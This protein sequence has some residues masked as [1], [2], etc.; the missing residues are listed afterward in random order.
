MPEIDVYRR[1]LENYYSRLEAHYRDYKEYLVE[2][3]KDFLKAKSEVFGIDLEKIEVVPIFICG[4][5]N[6]LKKAVIIDSRRAT[7]LDLPRPPEDKI[8]VD[9]VLPVNLKEYTHILRPNSLNHLKELVGAPSEVH[10]VRTQ[11]NA[12]AFNLPFSGSQLWP[13]EL[14][15]LPTEKNFQFEA[16]RPEQRLAVQNMGLNLLH[17]S[18]DT[19]MIKQRPYAAIVDHV[20]RRASQLPT[21]LC[22]DLIVCPDEKVFF[23]NYAA[24]YFNNV[25]VVGNGEIHLGNHTKLHAYQ[26]RHI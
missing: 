10:Q 17:G 3:P 9:N 6:E 24:V 13:V 1:L 4:I 23:S 14:R 16:L 25:L 8:P 11:T 22:N 18:V 20:L 19:E 2:P 5:R 21:F 7:D 26:I 15:H 12:S